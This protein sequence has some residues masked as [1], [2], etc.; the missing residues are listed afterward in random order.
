MA[1][2]DDMGPWRGWDWICGRTFYEVGVIFIEYPPL[3]LRK[4]V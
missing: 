3:T 1:G 2:K 4:D